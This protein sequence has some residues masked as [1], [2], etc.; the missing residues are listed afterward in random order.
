M[1]SEIESEMEAPTTNEQDVCEEVD[2]IFGKCNSSRMFL[3]FKEML[4]Q[5]NI[6]G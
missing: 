1:Q 5:H 2:D 4:R 6:D 3:E